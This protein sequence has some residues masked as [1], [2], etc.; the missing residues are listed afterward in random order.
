MKCARG[1]DSEPGRAW[2]V[3]TRGAQHAEHRAGHGTSARYSADSS[4][5][6]RH[7]APRPPLRHAQGRS[8]ACC[9]IYECEASHCRDMTR[10]R[11]CLPR[12]ASAQCAVCKARVGAGCG[13]RTR[14][15][16]IGQ[17]MC[18]RHGQASRRFTNAR[19][20][21]IHPNL[22]VLLRARADLTFLRSPMLDP[23]LLARLVKYLPKGGT[24]TLTLPFLMPFHRDGARDRHRLRR[25]DAKIST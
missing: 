22:F 10:H 6:Y 25:S 18:S 2:L 15:D 12:T 23:G 4:R 1:L 8:R 5:G 24:R 13:R 3:P 9:G 11:T 14:G 16:I 20:L 7:G 17:V 21:D 19:L